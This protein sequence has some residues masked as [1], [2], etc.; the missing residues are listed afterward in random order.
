LLAVSLASHAGLAS[1][2]D[3]PLG[4]EGLMYLFGALVLWAVLL[5]ASVILAVRRGLARGARSGWRY[6]GG[7]LLTLPASILL[8]ALIEDGSRVEPVAKWAVIL[9]PSLLVWL[10]YVLAIHLDDRREEN[11]VWKSTR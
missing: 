11:R 9:L 10:A 6:L 7:A 4:G 2:S 3:S 1:A 8:T 5:V